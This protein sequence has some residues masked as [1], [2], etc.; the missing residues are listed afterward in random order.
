VDGK[1]APQQK[2][3]FA[4]LMCAIACGEFRILCDEFVSILEAHIPATQRE[5]EQE[6][7]AKEQMPDTTAAAA[8]AAEDTGR[9][10]H[11][12]ESRHR[13]IVKMHRICFDLFDAILGLL[14]SEDDSSGRDEDDGES[15]GA[16]AE[17]AA[18]CLIGF[19]NVS[20]LVDTA[21]MWNF[22]CKAL[23]LPVWSVSDVS[24][25]HCI[26]QLSCAL[27]CSDAWANFSH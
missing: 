20:A 27:L 3:H 9:L 14:V 4:S 5:V 7:G 6:Q 13:R 19:R 21:L 10:P 26:A 11:Q 18:S 16:W 8:A 2:G 12:L 24:W 22:A 23:Q 1:G 17:L 25:I 15:G